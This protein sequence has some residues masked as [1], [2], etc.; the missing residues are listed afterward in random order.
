MKLLNLFLYLP[1]SCTAFGGKMFLETNYSMCGD[2]LLSRAGLFFNPGF[3][4]EEIVSDRFL[5]K[6]EG[7]T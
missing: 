6:H 7:C 4:L 2:F 3:F 5:E 1:L